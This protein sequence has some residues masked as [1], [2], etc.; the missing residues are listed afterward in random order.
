MKPR[1]NFF[2]YWCYR[3]KKKIKAACWRQPDRRERFCLKHMTYN[4]TATK[5]GQYKAG[6]P[7]ALLWVNRRKRPN[8]PGKRLPFVPINIAPYRKQPDE[9]ANN[10][11]KQQHNNWL[12][13]LS[14]IRQQHNY[15]HNPQAKEKEQAKTNGQGI[16]TAT[17][18]SFQASLC[19]SL[20]QD[21]AP[22]WR[23]VYFRS[24]VRKSF[25][26]ERPV[27]SLQAYPLTPVVFE[28]HLPKV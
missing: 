1:K 9:D 8:I 13:Q 20:H 14:L 11:P 4:D 18:I 10:C 25:I 12:L 17:R 6:C 26:A 15:T 21:D 24:T 22:G 27:Y 5:I 16:F 2:N 23:P 19:Y 28:P 3:K 7:S